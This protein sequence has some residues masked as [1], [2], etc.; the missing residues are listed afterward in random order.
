MHTVLSV[1]LLATLA[2]PDRHPLR[3]LVLCKA[4]DARA[5]DFAR[6]LGERF[7]TVRRADLNH[8][9]RALLGQ[10]DV[11]LVDWQQGDGLMQWM[12]Q[13]APVHSPLGERADWT[14]PTVLIGSAGLNVAASWG[15]RGGFG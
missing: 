11:V 2:A 15:V 12:N 10:S 9:D 14:V 3:I 4:G 8:F 6:F 5:D 1:A 13:K 7:T